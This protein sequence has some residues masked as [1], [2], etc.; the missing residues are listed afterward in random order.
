MAMTQSD[1][2]EL[3]TIDY[4]KL[5]P[6]QWEHFKRRVIGNA[7]HAQAHALR[8]LFAEIS[9]LLRDAAAGGWGIIPVSGNWLAAGASKGWSAY[10]AWCERR[11]AVRELSALDDRTLKDI[12]I[13]RSEI[14]SVIYGWGSAPTSERT[15]A[16]V[17]CHQP[18][19][20]PSA[21]SRPTQ[22]IKQ[23]TERPIKQAIKRSAA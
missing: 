23:P 15:I 13:N 4:R 16:P 18:Q 2:I 21:T 3:G 20:R 1:D 6:E 22:P 5:S 10:A 12:G 17:A 19:A 8:G 9:S 11:R 7:R 14:D